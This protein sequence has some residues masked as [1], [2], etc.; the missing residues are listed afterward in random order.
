MAEK[1]PGD[2]SAETDIYQYQYRQV[3]P[4]LA[5]PRVAIPAGPRRSSAKHLSS[6]QL[7]AK[8]QDNHCDSGKCNDENPSGCCAHEIVD[9]MWSKRP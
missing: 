1:E 2:D 5:K 7:T 9:P 6:R 4:E 3:P 8:E